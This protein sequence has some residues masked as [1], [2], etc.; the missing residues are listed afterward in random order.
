MNPMQRV[1]DFKFNNL[2]LFLDRVRG[3][4]LDF[5][6][7][8]SGGL[9]GHLVQVVS[10]DVLISNLRIKKGLHQ[11][12]STP[13]G[14]RTF[15][16]PGRDCHGFWWRG[17]QVSNNN[18]LVFPTSNELQCVSQGD[19][20]VFTISLSLTYIERLC[21]KHGIHPVLDSEIIQLDQRRLADLR[22]LAQTSVRSHDNPANMI[23]VK[24][25]AHALLICCTADTETISINK[26]KRD[27]AI[28]RIITHLTNDPAPVSDMASFCQIAKV[29]ER[30]LQYAFME[31]YG[32]PPNV[33]V[34]RW[35]LNTARRLLSQSNPSIHSV[36]EVCTRL[37]FQHPSQF[38]QDYKHLFAKL[39]SQTLA[40]KE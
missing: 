39:P 4:D 15:A 31:R 20:E 2:D 26:R 29:S 22:G 3:W 27:F 25:L 7:I 10:N 5:R 33:F 32:I 12:G 16:I 9:F 36:V 6:Q 37:G 38:T 13:P 30:T 11:M 35:K 21:E 14:F 24:N 1:I 40:R 8:D 23:T 28:S 19:F 18:L 34:K 17:H